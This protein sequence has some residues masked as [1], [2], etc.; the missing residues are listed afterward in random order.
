MY[1]CVCHGF[2][3]TQVRDLTARGCRSIAEVYRCLSGG[4]PPQCGKCVPYVREMLKAPVAA[5]AGAAEPV[6]YAA[7]AE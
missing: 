7:A 1:V 5:G 3:D 6:V 2:T 4:E